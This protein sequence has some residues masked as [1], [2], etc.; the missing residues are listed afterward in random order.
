MAVTTT[1]KTTAT[2]PTTKNVEPKESANEQSM[3]NEIESLK[4][5]IAL[6]IKDAAS[7]QK[8]ESNDPERDIIVVSLTRGRL[9]LSTEGH[10]HGDIYSF[11]AFG[12]E[13]AIPYADLKQILKNYGSFA[14]AGLFYICDEEFVEKQR[15]KTVYEKIVGVEKFEELFG[16]PRDKFTNIYSKMLKGQQENFSEI[17]IDKLVAN[18]DIDANIVNIVGEKTGKKIYDIVDARKKSLELKE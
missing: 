1:K 12:D 2:K 5:Q 8:S 6:L 17:M 3:K 7:G 18:E 16:L 9:N 15:L 11:E 4:A 13:L 14:K 10:G